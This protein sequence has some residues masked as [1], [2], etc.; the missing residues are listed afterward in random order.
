[1]AA[2]AAR[3][4]RRS[5]K[6]LRYAL[7]TL[8]LLVLVAGAA[9]GYI[10]AT[11]DPHDHQHHIVRVIKEKTGRTLAIGGEISLS[12]WPDVAV[13]LGRISLSERDREE[14]FLRIESARVRLELAPLLSREIV[15]SELVLAG[16]H[17]VITRYEDGRLNIDDLIGGEG[18][19][20]RF[21]IGRVALE[22]S[23][24]VYRDL[25]SGTRYE[26]T[27]VNVKA[28]RLANT[29][30]TPISVAFTLH[31]LDGE[32]IVHTKA[33]GRLSL[34]LDARQYALTRAAVEITGGVPGLTKLAAHVK[35]DAAVRA[36]ELH[37]APL[38]GRVQG[39][40]GQDE[41]TV[42]VDAA[43]LEVRGIHA[44]AEGVRAALAAKGPSGT[45]HLKLGLPAVRREGD[46]IEAP[47]AGIELIAQRGQHALRNTASAALQASI[48]ARALTIAALDG[49]F[50]VTGPQLPRK[51]LA[52]AVAGE[53]RVDLRNEGVQLN[54]AGK[55]GDSTVKARAT[56][57]G[58]A[59]P[60]YTFA[61][62]VDALDLDRYVAGGTA[63]QKATPSAEASL[64]QALSDIPA[65]GTVTVGVLTSGEAKASNVRLEIK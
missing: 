12:F 48:A 43:K 65:T 33:G 59:A 15:A 4:M 18:P 49:T 29:V 11:F 47:R 50:S 34:N 23:V 21:D 17:A 42:E 39:I 35:G 22:R 61:V 30:E 46:G 36:S 58:F 6:R 5:R 55:V 16:A 60:V 3:A 54:L 40:R 52:G 26:L 38:S 8:G 2:E 45:S 37:V 9:I 27:D 19:T 1:M 64:L 51:G 44:S 63:A 57:A 56:A 25:G 62:H 24:I 32:A 20:P 13:R 10:V 28:D 53:A 14:S 7:L 31:A 41:L